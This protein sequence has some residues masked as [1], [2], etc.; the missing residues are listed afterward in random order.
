MEID[1][2]VVVEV[3]ILQKGTNTVCNF[4]CAQFTPRIQ[5]GIVFLSHDPF[6][7][8]HIWLLIS[9][10]L[11]VHEGFITYECIDGSSNLTPSW[12][13]FHCFSVIYKT[14]YITY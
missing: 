6:I 2:K 4:E 11:V 8:L 9:T 10:F 14:L 1:H 7:D 5:K 3:K 12:P 13:L